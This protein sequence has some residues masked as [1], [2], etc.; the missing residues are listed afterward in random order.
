MPSPTLKR[1]SPARSKVRGGFTMIELLMVIIIIAILIGLLLPAIQ[2]AIRNA[3]RAAVLSEISQLAQAL[4]NFKS[5]YGDYPPS[6]F[7]AVEGGNYTA[8]LTDTTTLK[9]GT[10]ND[11]T[12]LGTGDI[13][14]GQLA[15]RSVSALRKFWPRVSTTGAPN[16]QWYDFNGNGVLDAPYVMHGHECLVFFLGGIGSSNAPVTQVN[17]NAAAVVTTANAP[18]V[19][20]GLAGFDKSP[21]NPFTNNIT[22]SPMYSQNRQPPIFEFSPSRLFVDPNSL[23]GMPAYYDSFGNSTP[24]IG[25]S[26]VN[27]YAYFNAYG[28]NA[29]DPNDVN[30]HEVDATG[31]GPIALSYSVAFPVLNSTPPDVSPAPNPYTSTLTILFSTTG[32]PAGPPNITYQDPQSFQIMSPGIDGLYGV[33]GQYVSN[34]STSATIS[35]PLDSTTTPTPYNT[36]D[37]TIRQREYDNLTNF[38]PG[39]LQ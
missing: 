29:Y 16:G 30:F 19:S 22:G 4:A 21:T 1:R 6:R 35:V 18:D 17:G 20:F 2:S 34:L 3:R 23:T 25:G 5:R 37:S 28:N 10:V 39:T 11:P 36:T 26:S 38:K 33:G 31:N 24:V 13:T 9:G 32:N 27:F 12:S 7:L 8:F 14:C 15:Q